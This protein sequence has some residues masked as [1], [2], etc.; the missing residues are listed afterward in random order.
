MI[1]IHQYDKTFL[2]RQSGILGSITQ[3]ILGLRK[4]YY[5]L[6]DHGEHLSGILSIFCTR[7][8]AGTMKGNW[9]D[10]RSVAL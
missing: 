3:H 5:H 10:Q 4:Y 2:K 6:P 1:V 7:A 8:K 9:D